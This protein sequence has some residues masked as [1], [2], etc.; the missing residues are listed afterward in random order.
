VASRYE[1]PLWLTDGKILYG[2]ALAEQGQTEQ[3]IAAM[4]EGVAFREGIG[5]RIGHGFMLGLLA[6]A[7][8]KV[9]EMEA[10]GNTLTAARA[11]M[12]QYDECW[13]AAELHRL[14]GELLLRRH[15]MHASE[16]CFQQA[17]AVARRQQA[18]SWELRAAL[19]LCR[20][21]Q[22]QGQRDDARQLL[23]DI[24]GWFTEAVD[25]VDLLEAKALVAELS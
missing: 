24:A 3:G 16:A 15:E 25:T 17:L 20:L 6:A 23:A 10:A 8:T 21:W 18:K 12:E 7:Y 11:V 1:L 13:Y 2:W 5:S 14:Q 4:R 9:G 22:Q 19:S